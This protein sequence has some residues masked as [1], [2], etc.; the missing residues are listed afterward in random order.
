MKHRIESTYAAT[1]DKGLIF[2][3]ELGVLGGILELDIVD[4]R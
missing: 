4:E 1:F 3:R 2:L